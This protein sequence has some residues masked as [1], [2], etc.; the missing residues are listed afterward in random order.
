MT[1]RSLHASQLRIVEIIEALGFGVIE[2]L[3]IRGGT[4][5]WET[6]T[7]IIETIKLDSERQRQP[8][9]TSPDLS[10]AKDFIRLFDQ[11]SRLGDGIVDI[12]VRHHRPFRLVVRRSYKELL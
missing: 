1:K 5:C 11:L 8:E 2:G 7:N 6:D 9:R 4:P 12:E 3:S 10:L